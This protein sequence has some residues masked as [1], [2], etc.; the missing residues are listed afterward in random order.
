MPLAGC[1]GWQSGEQRLAGGGAQIDSSRAIEATA[2]NLPGDEPRQRPAAVANYVMTRFAYDSLRNTQGITRRASTLFEDAN[3]TGCADYAVVATALLRAADIPSRLLLSVNRDWLVA[4]RSHP[5]LVPRGHVFVEVLVDG[6]WQ[7]LDVPY[8]QLYRKYDPD[9][10]VLPHGERYCQRLDDFWWAGIDSPAKL[11][12]RLR[13]C[14]E[15]LPVEQGP[16]RT[17]AGEA[18]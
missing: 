16:V 4:R 13:L 7:L 6:D 10:P 9:D 15:Q 11:N 3:L 14:A 8:L 5:F 18:L 1:V 17:L 2:R 12:A